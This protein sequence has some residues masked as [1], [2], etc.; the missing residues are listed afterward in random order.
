MDRKQGIRERG[1][2]IQI[3]FYYLGKRCRESLK[4]APTKAN[5]AYAQRLKAAIKHEIA[6]GTFS[7]SKHFPN[8]SNAHL[9]TRSGNKTVGE[10]LDEYIESARRT[11]ELAHRKAIKA[12]LTAT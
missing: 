4:L 8:S 9:G 7:Y 2:S 11:C 5:L 3:D 10:A 1:N 6:I 12:P